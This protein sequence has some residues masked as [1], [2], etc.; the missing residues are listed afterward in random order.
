M[1]KKSAD[2]LRT[3]EPGQCLVSSGA[4]FQRLEKLTVNTAEASIRHLQL[5]GPTIFQAFSAPGPK[6]VPD[7]S[8]KFIF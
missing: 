2:V 4:K 6:I 8:E 5:P 7:G 3:H 1:Q